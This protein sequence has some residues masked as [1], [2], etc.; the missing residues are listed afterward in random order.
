MYWLYV[1]KVRFAPYC[2]AMK[3]RLYRRILTVYSCEDVGGARTDELVR[4]VARAA[5]QVGHLAVEVH[6][7]QGD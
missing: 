7:V 6:Q 1:S 4:G 2:M 5:G 3:C